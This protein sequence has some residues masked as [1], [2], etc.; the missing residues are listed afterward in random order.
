[1]TITMP[2][3]IENSR[4]KVAFALCSATPVVR[5]SSVALMM[6]AKNMLASS[7]SVLPRLVRIRASA[8]ASR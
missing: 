6:P 4:S 1:M 5:R 2:L 8:S 3:M 7:I